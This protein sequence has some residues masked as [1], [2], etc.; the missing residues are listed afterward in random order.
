[1]NFIF[2][3]TRDDRTVA[4]ALEVLDVISGLGLLHI[5]FKDMG[6]GL[7]TL[8]SLNRAI[9]GAGGTSY[10]EVVS[11][12]D[13]D[14]LRAARTAVE[15]G[16]DCLLGGTNAQSMLETLAGS[17]IRYYPF[18]GRPEGHPTRLGGTP[19]DVAG[20]CRDYARLGC[21]GIDLL[22]Y[23]AFE[24]D[25][26]DLVRAAREATDGAVI[27]AGSVDTA[28]RIRALAEAGADA[29]TIGSA[30]FDGSFSPRKGSIRSQLRDIM[31]A[32]EDAAEATLAA[33]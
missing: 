23:C 6:V 11:T 2:M 1:M 16:V 17:D 3:L 15:V 27:V 25:P 32:C 20:H 29:F 21:A 22:A 8:R 13:S 31:A 9:K 14:C 33:G 28:E 4:D 24:A 12:E 18:A 5:G 19:E 26:L 10:M 7:D 30:A